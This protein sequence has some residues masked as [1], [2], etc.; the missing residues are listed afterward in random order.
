M[1]RHN[2][3][4]ERLWW[5]QGGYC[6][7]PG[8]QVQLPVTSNG[9]QTLCLDHDHKTGEARGLLCQN[10]NTA[11]GKFNDNPDELLHAVTYLTPKHPLANII[12][13]YLDAPR[14]TP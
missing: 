14:T 4:Y 6:A 2:G 9:G 5:E 1:Y 12:T 7:I 13:A 11:I 8:C 10:H 3:T